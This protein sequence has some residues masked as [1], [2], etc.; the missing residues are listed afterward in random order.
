[1]LISVEKRSI[2]VHVPKTGGNSIVGALRS[3]WSD[4]SDGSRWATSSPIIRVHMSARE[5]NGVIPDWA[6][7]YSFAFV[8]NPWD[9]MVSLWSFMTK[10]EI[11][12]D[13]WMKTV[14]GDSILLSMPQTYF[15]MGIDGRPLVSSI[16]RF[17]NLRSDFHNISAQWGSPVITHENKSHHKPY[18]DYYSPALA[19][20]VADRYWADIQAFGYRFEE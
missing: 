11:S 19:Q 1:M 4:A 14:P 13:N 18:R 15:L 6:S 2:F 16:G 9:R 20:L 5:L 12:F 7:Y 3:V 17:E 8:R 10:Q